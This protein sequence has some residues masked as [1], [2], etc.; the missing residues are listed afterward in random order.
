M[1]P[2]FSIWL[3]QGGPILEHFLSNSSIYEAKGVQIEA[4]K[5][6][7]RKVFKKKWFD[8][9]SKQWKWCSRVGGRAISS[10]GAKQLSDLKM[11]LF[12]IQSDTIEAQC[13]H[14]WSQKSILTGSQ[15]ETW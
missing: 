8:D 2:K 14:T 11:T 7:F 15:K 9:L 5:Y 12:L 4:P 13:G 10:K 1:G 3:S 6:A